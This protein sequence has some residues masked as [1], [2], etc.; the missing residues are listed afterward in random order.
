MTETLGAISN[1][2]WVPMAYVVLGLGLLFTILTKGVQF[3]RL[4]D[5][6][7]QLKEGDHG[8]TMSSYQAWMLALSNRLGIGSIAGVAIAVSFGG[9]GALL[10]MA[11]TG[12]V[13]SPVGFAEST[14]AQLFKRKD[15]G[16]ERGGP[17][18]YIKYGLRWPAVAVALSVFSFFGYGFIF[19]G[20]QSNTIAA[21]ATHAFNVPLIIPGLIITAFIAFVI[22][23][24]TK[25]IVKTAELMTPVMGI[26]YLLLAII[27]I[28]VNYQKIPAA[29]SLIVSAGLGM[30][31]VFGGI[32]GWAISWGV[33]RAVFASANGNGEGTYSAAAA[34]TTHPAKQGLVQAFSIYID[35]LLVCMATGLMIVVSGS[36]NVVNPEGGF[37]AE[38]LKG[39]V[40]GA[41]YVQ[42][43][44]DTALP[45]FGS[46]FVSIALFLFG[47]TCMT[48]YYYCANANL[49]FL[50]NGRESKVLSTMT[51]S[52]VVVICLV[53]SLVSAP[54]AW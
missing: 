24:G 42:V 50:L 26:G 41:N 4:P 31:A 23:G 39:I 51:K 27:V 53:G 28:V 18:Y 43:A 54:L 19:P 10:W 40:A 3:R 1:A 30:D 16:E 20:L 17:P 46:Y 11:I 8:G 14:I 5:M 6:I 21:A 47:F 49:M 22:F 9:P 52:G 38:N 48:F 29:I 2:I 12:L 33:R 13:A 37:L 36:Y 44:I 7:R 35:V 25:R 34:N 15:Q 32:I 45:G